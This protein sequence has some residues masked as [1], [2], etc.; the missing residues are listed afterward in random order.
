MIIKKFEAKTET[1]AI[2]LAK[3]ELGGAAVIMNIKTIKP[4]GLFKVFMKPSVEV[5]AAVEDKA[6]VKTEEQ[7][8]ANASRI[9]EEALKR[10]SSDVDIKPQRRSSAIEQ[11]LDTLADM[12]EKQMTTETKAIDSELDNVDEEALIDEELDS[13]ESTVKNQGSKIQ[14]L[15]HQK[16]INNEINEKYA[17]MLLEDIENVP[18]KKETLDSVLS[19]VYQRIVLKLG[20]PQVINL[21]EG[22]KPK[23]CFFVGSTGV[24]K[25]TTIAKIA[26]AFKLKE[27][28]NVALVTSDTYRIAAVEQLKTYANIMHLPIRVVYSTEEMEAAIKDYSNY[29]LILVDTAGRSPKNQEQC[30]ELADLISSVSP[31]LREVY[32]VLSATTKYKDLKQIVETYNDMADY[33]LVFT[34][35]DETNCYGNILNIRL[36]TGAPLSYTTCGQVVPDDIETLNAQAIAKQLIGGGE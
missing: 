9:I 33:R 20:Q 28:A 23:V 4:K 30:D 16:F 21:N 11:K 6:P 12:I 22:N 31:E 1:E 24:G 8:T 10:Q 17:N 3:A 5:T 26:S 2:E 13:E 25:T 7:A 27:K 29:D 32:L 35:L 34:K 36:D 15:L 14:H 18:D 19:K